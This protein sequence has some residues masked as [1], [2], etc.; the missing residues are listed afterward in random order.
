MSIVKILAPVTGVK[1]DHITLATAFEAAKPFAAHVEVLFICRDPREAVPYSDMPLPPG[2]V[3]DIVDCAQEQRKKASEI[4]R[5][6]L[7][8]AATEFGVTV[9]ESPAPLNTVTAS[10]REA[11]GDLATILAEAAILSDLVVIPPVVKGYNGDNHDALVRV[12][13]KAG[14]PV[15]LCAGKKPA[16]LGRNV[17]IGWDGHDAAAKALV[18]A[19]PILENAEAIE[20]ISVG[21]LRSGNGR[22]SEA[23]EYLA[24]HD[25]RCAERFVQRNSHS[26]ADALLDKASSDGCDLLVVGGYGHSR[27]MESVFGGVTEDIISHPTLPVLMVH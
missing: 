21:E 15:L 16:Q 12:L 14:R 26:S 3:Q 20:L 8:A 4:A 18:A 27:L 9:V 13:I 23:R 7:H 24:L 5:K 19:A 6:H 2:V 17:A 11:I 25:I 1:G 10:Y 22:L